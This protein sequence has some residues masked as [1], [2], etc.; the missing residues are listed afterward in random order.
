[1]ATSP[2][3]SLPSFAGIPQ[4]APFNPL[5]ALISGVQQGVALRQLPQQL[6]NDQLNQQLQQALLQAKV[7]S[8]P[9]EAQK[10]A[11][12]L[13]DLQNQLDPN[14]PAR[15]REAELSFLE[16]KARRLGQVEKELSGTTQKTITLSPGQKVFDPANNKVIFENPAIDKIKKPTVVRPGDVVLDENNQPIYTAPM[17][18]TKPLGTMQGFD[19]KSGTYGIFTPDEMGNFAQGIVPASQAPKSVQNKPLSTTQADQFTGLNLLEKRLDEIESTPKS[20]RKSNVGWLDSTIGAIQGTL[21]LGKSSAIDQN[22]AF[23]TAVDSLVGEFSFGRGGKALT[24]NEKEVLA[25]YL[26]S[27]TQSDARF[28]SRVKSF[29]DLIGE[30]RDARIE[31]LEASGYN[32]DKFKPSSVPSFNSEAEAAAAGLPAG[33][34]IIVNGVSGRW[35]P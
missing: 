33:T 23:R 17:G 18:K 25:K 34:P 27:L 7:N 5:E 9:L 31:S 12:V 21:G 32:V 10:Q 19:T 22:D 26:P 30:L 14:Y 4:P 35:Q 15:Q 20:V 28:E 13:R 16:Q 24:V 6:A 8:L 1:M 2:L 11:L 3:G 29:R